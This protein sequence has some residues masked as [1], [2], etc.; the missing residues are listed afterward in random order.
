MVVPGAIAATLPA[1]VTKT[2]A[3][4]APAPLGA[5]Y[6]MTGSGGAKSSLTIDLVESSSPPGVSSSMIS[7]RAPS[8]SAAAIAS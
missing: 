2:P 8:R 4:V 1:M 5:T 7:A 3:E 6:T